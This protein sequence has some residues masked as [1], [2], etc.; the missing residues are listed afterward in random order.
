M[1][2]NVLLY[3][4]LTALFLILLSPCFGYCEDDWQATTLVEHNL[5]AIWGSTDDDIYVAGANG[6]FLNYDG[7]SWQESAL[8]QSNT[9]YDLMSVWG[10]SP[11]VI[12]TTDNF[13]NIFLNDSLRWVKYPS[14]NDLSLNAIWG[15]SA[16]NAYAVGSLGTILFFNGSSWTNLTSSKLVSPITIT[17]GINLYCIWGSSANDVYT[18][19][20]LG[21]L[22]HFNG[23]EWSSV[24]AGT[25]QD[26]RALWGSSTSDVYAAGSYGDILHYDGFTWNLSATSS[27]I[28]LNS[29][30]GSGPNDVFA[31]GE[32][33][34]VYHYDG[35]SWTKLGN[36]SLV[37]IY[38]IWGSTSGKVYFACKNG[39]LVTYSRTDS[40]PPVLYYDRIEGTGGK[41]YI[42]NPIEFSFTEKLDATTINSSTIIMTS[43]STTVPAKLSLS[44]NGMVVSVSGA[45]AFSTPYMITLKGGS[46]GIKDLT[47]NSMKSDYPVSFTTEDKPINEGS[48]GGGTCFISTA[49]I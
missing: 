30:W 46:N 11:I 34:A 39:V 36:T 32:Y 19:G 45:D 27:G 44:I 7:T 47:G 8:I 13:G 6:T 28:K 49:K 4:V 33:G 22:F 41:A 5:N 26:I 15:S 9:P 24:N 10:I 29:L 40:I 38:A 48:G 31:A 3:G 1:R 16:T 14:L 20:E 21:K 35:I 2:T 18:G 23:S 12:I 42:S 43:G 17:T 37:D 25:S